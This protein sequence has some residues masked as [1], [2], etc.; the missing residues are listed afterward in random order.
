[1]D[2]KQFEQLVAR[3]DVYSKAHS[4]MYR[5]RVAGFALLGYGYLAGILALLVLLL[6]AS[7]LSVI[8]LK[9]AGLKILF[10]TAPFV[11]LVV[12]SCWVDM[13]APPGLPV[14]QRA[15]P[16]L[17][18]HINALRRKLRAP[19]F[20]RVLITDEFNAGVVQVPRL[21]P[22]GWHANH[23][24]LGMPLL[25]SVT[26][27]QLDAI[28]AHEF[29]H[30]AGGHARFGNW[31]YRLRRI[32]S[33]LLDELERR[34]SP[35][36]VLFRRFFEW[37]VPRFNAYSFPLARANEYEA[38]AAAVRATSPEALAQA[39]TTT[40]VVGRYLGSRYW[41]QVF[42]RADS[43]PQPSFLPFAAFGGA[44]APELSDKEVDEWTRD[45]LA[46]STDSADTH[47]GLGDRL[48]AFNGTARFLRPQGDA[49]ADFLLGAIRDELI[50]KLDGR[51]QFQVS[52]DWRRR[53]EEASAARNRLWSLSKPET[54]DSQTVDEVIE[55]A[56]L[57]ESYG[58]GQE[59]AIAILR[60]RVEQDSEHAALNYWL[61]TK[62]LAADDE[63]GVAMVEKAIAL[64]DGAIVA[65][66]VALR[67]FFHARGLTEQARAAH[68]VACKRQGLLD[69][70]EAERQS[71]TLGDKLIAHGLDAETVARIH[72]HTTRLGARRVWLAR[73]PM[74]NFPEHALFL[75]AFSI[76]PWYW[77]GTKSG[78]GILQ[79]RISR[80]VSLPGQTFVV[81]TDGSFYRFR[82]KLR[83]IRGARL[84]K[85]KDPGNPAPG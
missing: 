39:L 72:E 25:K 76:K 66:H 24:L 84:R 28:L 38:D 48:R 20:H 19:R 37:Y 8:Y 14:T 73:K 9:A 80:E 4:R 47:P 54:I 35:G 6:G 46:Q 27:E 11:W 41:P 31:L 22:V 3:Q 13:K 81:C 79:D 60:A 1:M 16:A 2:R 77:F 30:L 51:W 32:W 7:A 21:G 58:A 74:R 23:L 64:D 53:Y 55:R 52:E 85:P 45:A 69:A 78:G 70:A 26:P 15:A 44:L 67:D 75:L 17:F 10:V 49:S 50:A 36:L 61:G 43:T 63:S 82:R 42:A 62:L 56:N 33:Q 83:R 71:I 57:E 68:E 29:G 65:G 59:V 34:R 18:E 5:I 12:R 40:A